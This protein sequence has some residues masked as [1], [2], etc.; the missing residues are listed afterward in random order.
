MPDR[1]ERPRVHRVAQGRSAAAQ[2]PARQDG[3]G[4]E[5]GAAGVQPAQGRLRHVPVLRQEGRQGGAGSVAAKTRRYDT[6]IGVI[7]V[8]PVTSKNPYEL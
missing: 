5:A 8:D 6:I 2:T 4:A 7:R 1:G 3:G